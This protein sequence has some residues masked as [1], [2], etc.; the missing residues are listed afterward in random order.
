MKRLRAVSV[1]FY[2]AALYDGVLG[3]AFLIAAPALFEWVGVTPPNHFGYIHFPAALLIVFALLFLTIAR[4]PEVNRHLIPY[5]ILL[6]V[7]YCAVV[8]YH[9]FTAGIPF[10]WKPFAI[11]DVAFL[12][13]FVWAYAVLGKP[14]SPVVG[15]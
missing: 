13:L 15:T 14:R 6:K 10:I 3:V 9:W 12:V 2:L 1:L 4:R 5:G 8:F 7:S 11:V